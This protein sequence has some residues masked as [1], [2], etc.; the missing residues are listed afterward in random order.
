MAS[1][2]KRLQDRA[3]AI[4]ARMKELSDV[5]ERSEDQTNELKRLA[6]EADKVKSDLEFERSLVAKEAELSAAIAPP[7]APAGKKADE[8]GSDEADA[9]KRREAERVHIRAI[10]PDFRSLKA[11]NRSEADVEAA[12]RCG[13]WINATVFKRPE[14]I[15]WCNEHG[16][17]SRALAE[18]VNSTG[19]AL[20]PEEF[21]ARVIRLVEEYGTL[22][23]A[24][25]NVNMSRDVLTI[26]KRVSGTT[27]Y[28]MGEAETITQSDPGWANVQLVAKKIG[29]GCK[30][31]TEVVEDTAGV[32]SLADAV[33]AEFSTSLALLIDQ[34]GWI[35]DGTSTY[36]GIHGIATKINDGNHAAGIVT[37]ATGNTAFSTLDIEDFLACIGKLPIYARRGAAWY[38]SP[39][40]KAAS[41]DRL[42]YAAGGN[43]V[44]M[45]G[46]MAGDSFLGYPVKQIHVLN[47]TLTADTSAIKVLFGNMALSSIYARRREFAVKLFD[48]VY[49]TT[50]QLLLQGTMRF[51]VNHHSLGDGTTPGPVVA[52]KTP[53]S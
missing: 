35:G 53:G 17:Y 2:L 16:V 28:H 20:V 9:E 38:I 48:Q 23:M 1:E 27:A 29:V 40:G 44:E 34:D 50:D 12:Y 36:G 18:N 52:L 8:R 43:T 30:M 25:E 3:A 7:S 47:S 13:R 6:A 15:R 14:D 42:K 4:S 46:G 31:S 24:C 37:A 32:V 10:S 21:A 41:I 33:A 11:F 49:A 26:P 39:S 22:P 51:D 45:V 5:Q 19:G